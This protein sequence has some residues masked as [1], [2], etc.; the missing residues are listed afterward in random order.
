MKDA[1]ILS[2]TLWFPLQ[3]LCGAAVLGG[4]FLMA[5]GFKGTP[6]NAVLGFQGVGLMLLGVICFPSRQHFLWRM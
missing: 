4:V 1:H 3:V 2:A 6:M 5:E